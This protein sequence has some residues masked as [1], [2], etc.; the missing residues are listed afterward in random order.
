MR[1]TVINVLDVLPATIASGQA[2]SG[3]LNLGGLRLFGFV[4]PAAWTAANLTFQMS[5]DGGTTWANVYDSNGN[6]LTATVAASRYV[7]LDPANFA[8]LA[9]IKVRS[10]TSGTPVNQAAERTL[11]LVLRAV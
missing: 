9:M 7:A 6:E 1:N 2:V 11:Q 4:M 8:S 5:H 3:A 10:G